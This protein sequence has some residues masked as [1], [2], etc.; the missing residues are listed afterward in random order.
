MSD[1]IK[2]Y[3]EFIAEQQNGL[4]HSTVNTLN[5]GAEG[6]LV[7][8]TYHEGPVHITDMPHSEASVSQLEK[9]I[10]ARLHAKYPK[11]YKS[12]A[13]ATEQY[14]M[15]HEEQT[16]DDGFGHHT[17]AKHDGSEGETVGKMT[18]EKYMAGEAR[19]SH[20]FVK[21]NMKIEAMKKQ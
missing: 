10:G 7:H 17:L 9:G 2:K 18:A 6:L 16:T 11:T 15:A 19:H 3:A 21:H 4:R 13:H 12:A 20:G 5:E 8:S 1:Y 14:R